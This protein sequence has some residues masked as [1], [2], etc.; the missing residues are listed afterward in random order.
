MTVTSCS[1]LEPERFKGLVV[2]EYAE[3]VP[4]SVSIGRVASSRKVGLGNMESTQKR[5]AI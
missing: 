4:S 3:V 5:T 2:I 1:C